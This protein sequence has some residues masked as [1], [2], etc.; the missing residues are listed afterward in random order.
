MTPAIL[1]ALTGVEPPPPRERTS[2][3]SL[4]AAFLHGDDDA[5]VALFDRH[6]HRLFLYCREIVGSADRAADLTQELWERVIR[7]RAEGK[8]TAENPAGLFLRIGRNLCIDEIRRRR[9]HGSIDELAE[10]DHPRH[11]VHE[12]T[13]LEELVLLALPQLPEQQREV[14]VLNAYCGYRF[15]EIAEMTGAPEGAIRMRAWR[16]RV[17]LGRVLS[18]LMGIQED[19]LRD[20]VRDR[21][22]EII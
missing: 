5:L 11:E 20:I 14:L 8:A 16:A 1:N 3:T 2:D 12:L 7:L 21:P 15:D 17:H 10:I 9:N 13:H 18:A 6:N 22:E 4:F 19:A